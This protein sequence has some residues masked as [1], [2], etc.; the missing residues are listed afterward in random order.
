[1]KMPRSTVP[2]EV[3][4]G[5]TSRIRSKPFVAFQS[6]SPLRCNEVGE[7]MGSLSGLVA[8]AAVTTVMMLLHAHQASAHGAS[9]F[10]WLEGGRRFVTEPGHTN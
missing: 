5:D 2:V 1:M 10:P 8:L 3:S 4:S 6:P 9:Y 7:I